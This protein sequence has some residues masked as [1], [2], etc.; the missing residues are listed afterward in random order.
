MFLL[1]Y[2][3]AQRQYFSFFVCLFF[4]STLSATFEKKERKKNLA[5]RLNSKNLWIFSMRQTT[6]YMT[7]LKLKHHMAQGEEMILWR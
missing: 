3:A 5:D 4:A 1:E 7:I 2:D 6:S